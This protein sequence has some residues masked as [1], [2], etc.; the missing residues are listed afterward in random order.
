MDTTLQQT[1][2]LL[3]AIAPAPGEPGREVLDPATGGLVGVAPV[4]GLAELEAAIA[5]ARAAQ[6]AWAAAGHQA[7]SAA[8]KAAAEAV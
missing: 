5:A 1:D 2:S 7:R 6:P 3:E 8:L 4:H